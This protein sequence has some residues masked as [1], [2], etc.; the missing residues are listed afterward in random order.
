VVHFK[1]ARMYRR[2]GIEAVANG[3]I[4]EVGCQRMVYTGD[5]RA[6]AVGALCRDLEAY[7]MDPDKTEQ[8]SLKGKC[9]NIKH[10]MNCP[11]PL[12]P[13]CCREVDYPAPDCPPP[14]QA[15]MGRVEAI[16]TGR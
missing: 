10:T 13:A 6:T 14:M 16:L 4:A 11:M 8:E 1:E 3:F 7:L 15:Q 2:L 12:D 9:F 5:C